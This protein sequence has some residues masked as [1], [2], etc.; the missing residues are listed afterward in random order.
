MKR[1]SLILFSF[2]LLWAGIA[3]GET[4]ILDEDFGSWALGTVD[5]GYTLPGGWTMET[6]GM[7]VSFENAWVGKTLKSPNGTAAA[8]RVQWTPVDP[9]TANPVKIVIYAELGAQDKVE[10]GAVLLNAD[11]AAGSCEPAV[12]W[13]EYPGSLV[14]SREYRVRDRVN[15]GPSTYTSVYGGSETTFLFASDDLRKR[16][17]W[18]IVCDDTGAELFLDDISQGT[19][20]G[21]PNGT[22]DNFV[23]L[24]LGGAQANWW[25][26]DMGPN[27][28]IW[29]DRIQVI[30]GPF[31]P[32]PTATPLPGEVRLTF[33]DD[34]ETYNS[35]GDI[36]SVWTIDAG[37]WAVGTQNHSSGG[38]KSLQNV[39]DSKVEQ[40]AEIFWQPQEPQ[41][42]YPI[43]ASFWWRFDAQGTPNDKLD[44]FARISNDGAGQAGTSWVNF[45]ANWSAG[46]ATPLG[47]GLVDS[48]SAYANI[49]FGYHRGANCT[50]EVVWEEW[51][52]EAY[53]THCTISKAAGDFLACVGLTSGSGAPSTDVETYPL[54]AFHV[55]AFYGT[56]WGRGFFWLDDVAISGVPTT[57]LEDRDWASY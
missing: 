37:S 15:C 31:G 26:S 16:V 23:G 3:G 39:T 4:V 32:D 29:F 21:A 52:F 44:K 33:R 9:T 45:G 46:S 25:A 18:E 54:N 55:G 38:S 22:M 10:K 56:D 48:D 24:D 13:Y 14:G 11:T 28:D 50:Q 34:F 17:K 30:Q 7:V 6:A 5:G 1:T 53:P 8:L 35:L 2:S 36:M 47:T 42:G 27:G 19:F 40:N 57:G 12:Y 51:V 41:P 20:A 43:R 49:T